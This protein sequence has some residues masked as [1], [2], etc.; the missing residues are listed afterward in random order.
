MALCLF[1]FFA[2][3]GLASEAPLSSREGVLRIYGEAY[4]DGQYS[5]GGAW[6]GT[7]FAVARD[8]QERIILVTN[9]HCVDSVFADEE[10]R[11]LKEKGQ[12]ITNEIYIVN[13]DADHLVPAEVLAISPK[14]DLALIRV[15]SLRNRDLL[16]RIWKG[17]PSSLVQQTVYTA[18]FPGASDVIKSEKAYYELH[19]EIDS[20]TFADGKVT[21]IID[22]N[23]THDG[24]EVIQHTAATNHGN[25]GGPLLDEDGNVVG[26]NTWSAKDGEQT[27]WSISNRELTAFLDEH[28]IAYQEGK[29][30]T[31]IDPAI[32]AIV[33]VAVL[34]VLLVVGVLRQRKV[35]KTQSMQLEELLK[36]RLTQFT[37]IIA[38]K[39]VP[40]TEQTEVVSRGRK[41]LDTIQDDELF[42]GASAAPSQGKDGGRVLRCDEG[43]LAGKSFTLKEKLVIGRDPKQCDVVFPKDVTGVSRVHCTIRYSGTGVI[44]RDENS[45]CGTF[46]DGKRIEPGK[47]IPLHRGHKIGIGSAEQIFTLHSLH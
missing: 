34:T 30:T 40:R 32:I 26:V 28:E 42:K 23:Q 19:S 8:D 7:A 11:K 25:S 24:G 37:S 39:R 43:A 46:L 31:K 3:N 15:D 14:T 44:L 16:L 1:C 18:G 20:V 6:T 21:R 9:R 38:P 47:N 29:R 10:I 36:K 35:N 33:V 4:A 22:K 12:T 45:S 17:D 2:A 13:D 5:S 27:Y 41:P